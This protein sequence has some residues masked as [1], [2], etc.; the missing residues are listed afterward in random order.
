MKYSS[1]VK[2]SYL[3]LCFFSFGFL[4]QPL[5]AYVS[6]PKNYN[7]TTD[8]MNRGGDPPDRGGLIDQQRPAEYLDDRWGVDDRYY[9]EHGYLETGTVFDPIYNST[10]PPYY[11]YPNPYYPET[12][13]LYYPYYPY[14]YYRPGYTR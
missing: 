5:T 11:P 4:C 2:S 7:D 8:R 13:E 10:T 14:E 1:L 9:Y 12:N 3:C 6:V